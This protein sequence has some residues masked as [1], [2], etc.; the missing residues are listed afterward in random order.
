MT[1]CFCGIDDGRAM[2]E[3]INNDGSMAGVSLGGRFGI[4]PKG[5][6]NVI[7]CSC[8]IKDG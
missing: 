8:G 2:A 5:V 6:D 1:E 3:G 7:K 4:A